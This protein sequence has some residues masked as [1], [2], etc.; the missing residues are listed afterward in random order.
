MDDDAE[1]QLRLRHEQ[2][3]LLARNVPALVS[4]TLILGSGA[5]ALLWSNQQPRELIVGWLLT[6]IV[7]SLW[8]LWSARR[9]WQDTQRGGLPA[10]W[11]RTF[12][13]AS[14]LA[15]LCWGSL[16]WLFFSPDNPLN[17]AVVAIV[18]MATLSSATQSMLPDF[19][20]HH[21]FAMPRALP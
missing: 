14:A 9:F 2:I 11:A 7:L 17:L 15:G 6:L 12:V 18:L 1:L 5:A 8:R 19:P 13:V 4:G 21:A 16:A 3:R 20:S 10:Q